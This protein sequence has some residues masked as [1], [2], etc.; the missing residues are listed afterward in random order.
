MTGASIAF[1]AAEN[2]SSLPDAAEN[3]GFS[4]VVAS[5]VAEVKAVVEV[6]VTSPEPA[7]PVLPPVMKNNPSGV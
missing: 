5:V 4:M 1:S 2:A 7:V 6:P 3:D